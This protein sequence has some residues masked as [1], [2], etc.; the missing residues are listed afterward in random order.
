[1]WFAA[2]APGCGSQPWFVRFER[3]L[4]EGS[5]PVL[6]LLR[7]DPFAGRPPRYVRARLYLY[8]FTTRGATAWWQ[9]EEVGPYCPPLIL[10]D[11]GG[12]PGA[13][14]SAARTAALARLSHNRAQ[15]GQQD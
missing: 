4:L 14:R 10:E 5:P 7:A 15:P 13:R 6:R 1:M 8:R 3:R 2:L 11:L 12:E 9:R